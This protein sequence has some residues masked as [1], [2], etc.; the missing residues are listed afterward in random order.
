FAAPLRNHYESTW[1]AYWS[2]SS[3][4]ASFENVDQGGWATLYDL[5][6]EWDTEV[7]YQGVTIAQPS[8]Q[9][10]ALGRSITFRDC[11][12]IGRFGLIP[13]Q[14][15]LWRAINCSMLDALMEVDK[16][17][18][19]IVLDGTTLRAMSVQSSSIDLLK[20]TNTKITQYMNGTPRR[21]EIDGNSDIASL[22]VGTMSYGVTDS[23]I[24]TD[25]V[26]REVMPLGML[27]RSTKDMSIAN[28]VITV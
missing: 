13:T 18:E 4:G 10:Y 22:G 9:T 28:G 2:T 26:I 15:Q 8:N 25:C 7:E 6:P 5:R 23:V 19:Q 14:N 16:L 27:D 12:A 24:A 20:L 21:T 1:P 3:P 17:C 11:R